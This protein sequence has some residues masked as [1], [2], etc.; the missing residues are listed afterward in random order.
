MKKCFPIIFIVTVLIFVLQ[1]VATIFI[2]EREAQYVLKTD[3]N[4]YNISEKLSV[5]D[6]DQ[7][8]DFKVIDSNDDTYTFSL[9]Y[10]LNKQTE[11]IKDIKYFKTDDLACIFPI[12]KR[13]TTSDVSCIYE[14][15]QVNYTYLN[16]INN[17]SIS[18]IVSKLKDDGYE[19]TKWDNDVSYTSS[20]LDYDTRKINVYQDNILENYTFLIW[21][22]RGLFILKSNDS[23]AKDFLEHDQYDNRLSA[24]VGHY[25]VSADLASNNFKIS[26]LTYYNTDG[27]GKGKIYFDDITSSDY[28]FNGVYNDKLYMT[29]V[30]N[31]KQYAIDPL[32]ET[33][34]VVG[35]KKDGFVKVENGELINVKWSTF[36]ENKVYFTDSVTNEELSNQYNNIVDMKK[37]RKFYYFRTSDG[38]VYRAHEDSLDNAELLFK[39]NNITEWVVKNGDI[40]VVSGDMVYFYTDENG[41]MP[42][43]QNSE[44]V[45]NHANICDFWEA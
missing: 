39:F 7:Y 20:V 19:N 38:C 18:E 5:I 31:A 23:V 11:I 6:D 42:I 37:I 21:R 43:A 2:E 1:Y 16:Q 22:Y 25:Y 10:D 44:L 40:L 17:T 4:E 8:Y 41:V 33:V 35:T 30:G 14:G 26:E 32:Y 3:D 45:Y 13:G 36:L 27:Y 24:L 12:Y 28:Y 15:K 34:E 29:D 9:V